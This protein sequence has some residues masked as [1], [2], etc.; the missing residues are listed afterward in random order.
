MKRS[1][2][3]LQKSHGNQRLSH[4]QSHYRCRD[5]VVGKGLE[6]R[7]KMEHHFQ[8]LLEFQKASLVV[9][10]D[11][12]KM[13]TFEKERKRVLKRG[14][15]IKNECFGSFQFSFTSLFSNNSEER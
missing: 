8:L 12:M 6:Q 4:I 13:R 1:A 14:V 10:Q 9:Y 15:M 7:G 11:G 5:F 3:E 2:D